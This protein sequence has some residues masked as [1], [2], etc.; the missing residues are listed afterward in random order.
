M[1]LNIAIEIGFKFVINFK[2][3]CKTNPHK[4]NSKTEMS[5]L[6]KYTKF[7][8]AVSLQRIYDSYDAVMTSAHGTKMRYK[9]AKTMQNLLSGNLTNKNVRQLFIQVCS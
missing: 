2:T 3:G 9:Y 5:G 4:I 1:L 6:N 8:F 7:Y